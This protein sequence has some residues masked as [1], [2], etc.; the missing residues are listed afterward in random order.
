MRRLP[1]LILLLAVLLSGC[2]SVPGASGG[3]TLQPRPVCFSR[4]EIGE[5]LTKI[6]KLREAAAAC[7]RGATHTQAKAKIECQALVA[8]WQIEVRAC[9]QKLE[10]CSSRKCPKCILPWVLVGVGVVVTAV[11][12]GAW[13][14]RELTRGVLP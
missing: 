12:A 11:V 2:A 8:R 3:P 4:A 14:Y 5:I 9:Q 6:E 7:K 13:G 1:A 10:A